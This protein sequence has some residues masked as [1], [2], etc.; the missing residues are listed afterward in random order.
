AVAVLPD[1]A[2]PVSVRG[3]TPE[4]VPFVI[5]QPGLTPDQVKEFSEKA[6]QS[7]SYGLLK[8]EEFIRL[9]LKR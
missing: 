1:H 8:G 5:C 4:P 6:C 3:H 9:F 2:T 7:G